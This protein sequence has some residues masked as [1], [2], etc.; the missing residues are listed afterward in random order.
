M[1]TM[2]PERCVTEFVGSISRVNE[3]IDSMNSDMDEES[4]RRAPIDFREFAPDEFYF[5]CARWLL[6]QVSNTP[7]KKK[8][9]GYSLSFDAEELLKF[10]LLLIEGK[11]QLESPEVSPQPNSRNEMKKSTKVKEIK[12]LK[13]EVTY[14][15]NI[16]SGTKEFI[17][18]ELEQMIGSASSDEARRRRLK[19]DPDIPD[20]IKARS[21]QKID[22]ENDRKAARYCRAVLNL[23]WSEPPKQEYNLQEVKQKLDKEIYGLE[24]VKERLVEEVAVQNRRGRAN[25]NRLC[26]VGPPGTGKT[27]ISSCIAEALDRP[28]VKF[29]LAGFTDATKLTGTDSHWNNASPGVI[30][31]R[32]QRAGRKDP[33]FLLDEIDK[34]KS[35]HQGNMGDPASALL[36]IL[37]PDQAENFEDNYLDLEL[38]LS[39]VLFIATANSRDPIIAPLKDRLEFVEFEGY[40]EAEK[41]EIARD[42]ILPE[43][44]QK[45]GLREADMELDEEAI[46]RIAE[47]SG[48]SRGLRQLKKNI[49][50]ICRK[51]VTRSE[52][53]G[54]LLKVTPGFIDRLFESADESQVGFCLE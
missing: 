37:D 43:V 27:F 28:F 14:L 21:L 40:S 19:V 25:G 46:R 34:V 15:L 13:N 54:K 20:E 4:D 3:L 38:D 45:T 44:E 53:E 1:E 22:E 41:F 5:F 39:Q 11:I 52:K 16:H 32:L 9:T 33:V 31:D 42:Y 6:G 30:A 51:A 10:V 2:T 8:Y 50:T 18:A 26:L 36:E 12:Q 24:E 49:T 7:A 47:V 23:P 48:P 17:P 29:S 35:G